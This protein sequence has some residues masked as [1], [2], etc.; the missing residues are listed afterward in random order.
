MSKRRPKS[1]T[2][3][4]PEQREERSVF[5]AD[6][7]WYFRLLTGSSSTK[8]YRC[9]GCDHLIVPA[10]PHTVVWPVIKPLLS[11]SAIDERRHWH[12][13]CWRRKV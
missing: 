6:G 9:P 10:T 3:V 11:A 12:S 1:R 2:R 5:K 13:W 8:A 7:Q 4:H